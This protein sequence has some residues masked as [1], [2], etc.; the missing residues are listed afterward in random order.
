MPKSLALVSGLLT[1]ASAVSVHAAGLDPKQSPSAFCDLASDLDYVTRPFNPKTGS[2]ATEMRDVTPTP[3][4]NG[5]QNNLAYYVMGQ[6]DAP[7]QLER[8]S[9][10]LN[11]NNDTESAKAHAELERVAVPV[12]KRLLGEEPKGF[13]AAVKAGKAQSWTSA[14]WHVQ[15]V[16]T[17][18][19]AKQGRDVSVQFT[20]AGR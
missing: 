20:P 5:L 13:A 17:Q 18:R 15:V 19:P 4:K 14:G 9:L 1:A 7:T 12:A 3:G 10:I 2:C 6:L 8:I 16:P 11:I